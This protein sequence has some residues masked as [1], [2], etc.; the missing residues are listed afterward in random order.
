MNSFGNGWR[1]Y[2]NLINYKKRKLNYE[3]IFM[4]QGTDLINYKKRKLNY[5]DIFIGTGHW[6]WPKNH[7][8]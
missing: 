7:K 6:R 3:D 2:E 1:C 8:Q 5:E 4:A